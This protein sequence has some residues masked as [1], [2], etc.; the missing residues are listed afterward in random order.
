[1][2]HGPSLAE[3]ARQAAR[4][5]DRILRGAKPA[6]LPIEQPRKYELVVNLQ[7]ARALQLTLPA[8]L[9]SRADHVIE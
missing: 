4:Y 3:L 5:V 6:D 8:S 7:A 1:M 9:L 2:S